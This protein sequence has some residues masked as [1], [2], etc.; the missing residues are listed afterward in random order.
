MMNRLGHCRPRLWPCRRFEAAAIT[1][2][3]LLA[4]KLLWIWGSHKQRNVTIIVIT[5]THKRPERL[6]D[7]TRFSQTLSHIDNLHWIVI[8]DGTSKVAA[9]ERIL[10]RSGLRY[11]Y[12]TATTEP[13][14]PKRGWTHRNVAL[15]YIRRHYKDYGR[16]AV[17]YFAD[18]DNSYDV[19]LFNNYI[20]N[21]KAVGIWA[22]GLA[23]SALVEAPHVIN[24]TITAWD[25]VY[26]PKRRFATDMAGFAINLELILQFDSAQ[27][28]RACIKTVPESCFLE[29]FNITKESCE[30][31][32]YDDEPKEILVWHT[33]TKNI[34]TRGEKHGYVIE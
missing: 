8:E 25:V 15:R 20:R 32:G 14:F 7:M 4:I 30:A 3:L 10:I 5:P 13:G 9:V 11:V 23:G 33:K 6:A 17:V 19:R 18:D 1:V 31:F 2:L 27:F 29:Q 22:V 16:G 26:A 24:G 28:S 34:G 21:V 12:F